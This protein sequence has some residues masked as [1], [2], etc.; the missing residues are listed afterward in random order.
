MSLFNRLVSANITQ[1]ELTFCDEE[2]TKCH[3]SESGCTRSVGHH[4]NQGHFSNGGDG[5]CGHT[6]GKS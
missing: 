5:G 6:W 4:P 2:C 1:A 3:A